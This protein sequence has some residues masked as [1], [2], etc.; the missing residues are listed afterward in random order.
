[1]LVTTRVPEVRSSG[2]SSHATPSIGQCQRLS[3]RPD[4]TRNCRRSPTNALGNLYH[5]TGKTSAVVAPRSGILARDWRERRGRNC[6]PTGLFFFCSAFWFSVTSERSRLL[7]TKQAVVREAPLYRQAGS[8]TR[9]VR[10]VS[11][12]PPQ[13]SHGSPVRH[14]WT[15]A[16][17]GSGLHSPRGTLAGWLAARLAG[18]LASW[19]A[20]WLASWLAG[21]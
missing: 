4:A 20:G 13:R 1:M 18:W 10:S 14:G 16:T 11:Q 19:L 17:D 2:T 6:A 21:L 15:L 8:P 3:S 5:R 9:T 7:T 12:L